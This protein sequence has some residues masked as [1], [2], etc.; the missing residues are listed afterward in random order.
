MVTLS[1]TASL[2]IPAFTTPFTP[3]PEVHRLRQEIEII[4]DKISAAA[5]FVERVALKEKRTWL[6]A[7]YDFAVETAGPQNSFSPEFLWQMDLDE[8]VCPLCHGE[9][10]HQ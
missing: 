6:E 10:L 4:N 2:P 8:G 5:N 9:K 7:E 3:D 1:F